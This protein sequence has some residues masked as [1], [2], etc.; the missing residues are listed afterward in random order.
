MRHRP[1]ASTRPRQVRVER[2]THLRPAARCVM[3]DRIRVK[4]LEH[5]DSEAL[6]AMVGRC[7]AVSLYR[8]FHGVGDGVRY[9]QEV[10]AAAAGHDSYAAWS[11]DR[12]VGLGNLHAYDDTAEIGVLVED[13]WQRRGVGTALVVALVRQARERRSPFLRAD[14][15]ADDH[16]ALRALATVGLLRTWSAHGTYTGLI[17]L[18]LGTALVQTPSLTTPSEILPVQSVHEAVGTATTPSGLEG[19]R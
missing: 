14:L 1:T 7:S 5:A 15:L 2:H 19:L 18:G 3:P 11:G 16:F 10:L 12:C 13:R 8:R 17:D 4:V 6:L 9:A